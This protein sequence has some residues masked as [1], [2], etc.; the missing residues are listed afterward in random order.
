MFDKITLMILHNSLTSAPSCD[1]LSLSLSLFVFLILNHVCGEF[2]G[3]P[4]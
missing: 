1:I 4:A 2:K 3:M